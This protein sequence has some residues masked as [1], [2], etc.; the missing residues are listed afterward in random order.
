MRVRGLKLIQN[1]KVDNALKV[2]PHAGAWI[3]TKRLTNSLRLKDVAPHAGAWIETS[4]RASSSFSGRVAPHAG[5]WI[6]TCN[7]RRHC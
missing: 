7:R 6:E 4:I 5:A 2:A 1:G 3:E